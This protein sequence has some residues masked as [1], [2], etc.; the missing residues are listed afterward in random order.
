M[1]KTFSQI[2]DL[3][4]PSSIDGMFDKIKPEKLPKSTAAEITERAGGKKAAPVR[5]RIVVFAAAAVCL[6][7]LFGAIFGSDIFGGGKIKAL[8]LMEGIEPNDPGPINKID[9]ASAAKAVDFDVRLFK[10][11]YNGKENVLIS[12]LSV[13]S[14]LAMTQNGAR[15]ET[16]EQMERTLGMSKDELNEFFRSYG[17]TLK[18][19]NDCKLELANSIWFKNGPGFTV[20]RDF[21]QTNADFYGADAYKAP[22]DKTTLKDINKW[23]SEKTDGMIKNIL[24]EIPKNAVMYLANALCFEAEW[25]EKYDAY[26]VN[27]GTFTTSDGKERRVTMM[28]SFESVY[29]DDGKATGFMK[30]YKG[31]GYAFVAMLP[32][33]GVSLDD[34]IA[35]LDG[36]AVFEMLGSP[37]YRSV[38]TKTPN[39]EERIKIK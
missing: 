22:F 38:I 36:Q 20:N 30:Y 14:A 4:E 17:N 29:F 15:G 39:G 6:A 1:K 9:P 28:S 26:S 33:E 35:S 8:D 34:Y 19:G 21:L 2:A 31:R 5:R 25:E 3:A 11:S 32:G 16:L 23:V 13:L 7:V 18:S 12:P 37:E 10:E 24:D 27:E